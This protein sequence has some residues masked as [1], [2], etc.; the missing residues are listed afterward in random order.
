MSL[1]G[2]RNALLALVRVYRSGDNGAAAEGTI[3]RRV[4]SQSYKKNVPEEPEWLLEH[5][6]DFLVS[7]HKQPMRSLWT[8]SC[9]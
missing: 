3:R 4:G 6:D 9:R 5:I 1:R 2:R 7:Q 8:A